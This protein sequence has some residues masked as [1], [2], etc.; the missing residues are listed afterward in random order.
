MNDE[1]L[2]EESQKF[3]Q[4]WLWVLLITVNL[5][6]LYGLVKQFSYG[7]PIGSSIIPGNIIA[8]VITLVFTGVIFISKLKTTMKRDALYIRFYPF[9]LK[10]KRY[11]WEEISQ[12]FVRKY[13]P[14]MEYGGWGVRLGMFGKGNALNVSGNMGIQLVFTNKNR[15]L[16]GTRKAA[17]AEAV[18]A[19]LKSKQ[20]I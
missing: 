18:L 10:T 14:I 8:F 4:P 3:R 7:L 2:F 20:P 17:E 16:I 6:T 5:I 1:I 13:N 12:I 15:L 19:Q 11:V 9:H